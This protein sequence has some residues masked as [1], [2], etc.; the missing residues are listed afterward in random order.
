MKQFLLALVI[1]LP[2]LSRAQKQIIHD[3]NVQ[4]RSIDGA[5][6][7]I[8]VSGGIDLYLS[9]DEREALAVSAAR[10]EYRDHIRT[11]V[12]DGVL[13]IWFDDQGLRSLRKGN[14]KLRVYLAFSNIN[15]LTATGASNVLVNGVIKAEKLA[16]HLTGASDFNGAVTTSMLTVQLSGA[17]DAFVTG[18]AGSLEVDANGASDFKGY[19]LLTDAC[20]VEA[21]G[22]SDVRITVKKELNVKA[23]GAS[24]IFYKGEGVIRELKTSGASSVVKKD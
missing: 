15:K 3:E 16:L 22:A 10:E 19:E 4:A 14:M 2:A 8:H 13:R 20:H 1:L 5:F 6:Q 21:S 24:G 23:S 18:A 7:A 17:S 12:E 11:K 9:Q